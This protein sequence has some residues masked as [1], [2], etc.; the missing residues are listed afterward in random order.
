ME[1]F[2]PSAAFVENRGFAEQR[3]RSLRGLRRQMLDAPIAELIMCFAE[4]PYCFTLQCCFGHFL[5]D[6]DDDDHTLARLTDT[7][8]DGTVLYRIAYVAWC[9][10]AGADGRRLREDLW[11][12]ATSAPELIQFGSA[13][14]FWERQVNSYV[15]QVQP[16]RYAHLDSVRLEIPEALRVQAVRDGFFDGLGGLLSEHR[17]ALQRV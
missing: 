13:T 10:D 17:R 7:P 2:V 6:T 12:V 4:L 5:R 11:S 15:L 3:R 1:T 8:C 14:W 16:V 9:I